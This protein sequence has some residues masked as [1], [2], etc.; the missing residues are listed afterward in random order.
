MSRLCFIFSDSAGFTWF[1]AVP[2][3]TNS[4]I[5]QVLFNSFQYSLCYLVIFLKQSNFLLQFYRC[6]FRGFSLLFCF[7]SLLFCFPS[8]LFC[9]P[10]LFYCFKYLFFKRVDLIFILNIF[11]ALCCQTFNI[12]SFALDFLEDNWLF[13]VI[14]GKSLATMLVCSPKFLF[15]TLH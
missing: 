2:F 12:F 15:D 11:Y 4:C 10:S 3:G 1:W 8:L 13:K 14:K 5:G 7:P 9:F 6:I